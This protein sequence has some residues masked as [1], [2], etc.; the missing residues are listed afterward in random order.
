L[1]AGPDYTDSTADPG[2]VNPTDSTYSGQVFPAFL[3]LP[4]FL[5]VSKFSNLF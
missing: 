2:P 3:S 5:L 1:F 4:Y